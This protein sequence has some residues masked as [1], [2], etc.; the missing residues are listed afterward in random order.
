M[1]GNIFKP[2]KVPSGMGTTHLIFDNTTSYKTTKSF[3]STN[4]QSILENVTNLQKWTSSQIGKWFRHL[5]RNLF[6]LHLHLCSTDTPIMELC[7][8]R[9]VSDT[10]V[11]HT[12]RMYF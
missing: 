7:R 1:L 5:Q 10:H 8:V 4:Y 2:L 6:Q 3:P 9:N 12:C 11:G